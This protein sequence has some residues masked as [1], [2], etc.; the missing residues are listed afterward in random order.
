MTTSSDP[1]T[2]AD[3]YWAVASGFVRDVIEALGYPQ[4]APAT[5]VNL[6]EIALQVVGQIEE[7]KTQNADL[8]AALKALLPVAE[9]LD[10]EDVAV[11]VRAEAAIA[12]TEGC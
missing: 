6:S 4:P 11:I 12:R 2:S 3:L 9:A 10:D 1:A 8:L 7:L 5:T